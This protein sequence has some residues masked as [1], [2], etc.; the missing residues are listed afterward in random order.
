MASSSGSMIVTWHT[1]RRVSEVAHKTLVKSNA[2]AKDG[3]I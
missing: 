2:A 1:A 3:L